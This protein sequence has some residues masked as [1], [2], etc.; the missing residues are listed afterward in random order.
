MAHEKRGDRIT[1]ERAKELFEKVIMAGRTIRVGI[2]LDPCRVHEQFA[3]LVPTSQKERLYLVK[4]MCK[5]IDELCPK[6]A[7]LEIA[8]NDEG[9]LTFRLT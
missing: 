1:P 8:Y 5:K 2:I 3:D 6:G 7:E 4:L 9:N